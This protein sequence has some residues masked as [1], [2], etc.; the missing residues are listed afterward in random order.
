MTS[1]IP[2][3]VKAANGKA[4]SM[5]TLINSERYP[6]IHYGFKF[7]SQNIGHENCTY[8][9]PYFCTYLLKR[10]MADFHPEEEL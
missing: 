6:D 3:E 10:F 4:K 5:N 1:L 8:T 2:A 9:F 7:S